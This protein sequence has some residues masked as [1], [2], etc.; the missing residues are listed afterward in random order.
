MTEAEQI[1]KAKDKQLDG[2]LQELT[3]LKIENRLLRQKLDALLKRIYGQKSEVI[4][5]HQLM[6]L[7]AGL[8]EAAKE[9]EAEN[10]L[11][12][13]DPSKKGRGSRKSSGKI[14]FPAD[15]Q[16]VTEY[17]DPQEVLDDPSDWKLIGEEVSVEMDFQPGK[18]IKRRIVR[19]K[20]VKISD[21]TAPPV[22]VPA[23]PKILEGSLA[24]PGLLSQILGDRFALGLP[25]YRQEQNFAARFDTILPRQ[26]MVRW[27]Q[28]V[29]DALGL[30]YR[31][32]CLGIL[33]S[34]Y[35]QADETPIRYLDANLPKGSGLGYLWVYRAPD[36]RVAFD[37]HTSRSAE[38][39]KSFLGEWE[40]KLQ[41]DGYSAYP[42]FAKVKKGIDL[43]GCW[44]HARRM[45]VEA[46]EQ[47]PRKA[48][49]IIWQIKRLYEWEAELRHCRA[50]PKLREAHRASNALMVLRRLKKA[51]EKIR[52][53]YLPQSAMGK[54]LSYAL[55]RW[56]ELVKFVDHGEV[57]IDNNLIENIIRPTAVGKKNWLFIG[58]REAGQTSAIYYSLVLTCRA[59]GIDP[60]EY[61]K[62][63][64]ERLPTMTNQNVHELTPL[65]W[66]NA[67][68]QSQKLAA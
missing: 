66:L 3:H 33:E 65:N 16:E 42:C 11:S 23:P 25:Y 9:P 1:L 17:L 4:D 52:S 64:L 62:D 40:G 58:S 57:E 56:P 5:S 27:S 28:K 47:A 49:W 22:V 26:V 2:L 24:T 8:P 14:C 45:F 63:V 38:C 10:K 7:L 59:L 6:L 39:L 55:E 31:H 51:L 61:L 48:G 43:M 41:C 20:Y 37:W 18:V 15:A 32:H 53:Q 34:G 67:R 19:R 12:S 35:L 68:K 13:E 36:G 54:A 21:R 46:I 30:V 50:G 60:Y 29:A 44:A